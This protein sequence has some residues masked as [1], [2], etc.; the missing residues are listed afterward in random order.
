[1]FDTDYTST[2]Y[3]FVCDPDEC[4]TL[5]EL[6]TSNR[7]GFPS[8]SIHNTCPCGRQM[9]LV[10]STIE[11]NPTVE[12]KEMETTTEYN[13]NLL[14]AYKSIN[15]GEVTYPLI[16]VVDLE[17]KLDSLTR[18]EKQLD[19]SN[20]QLREIISNMT[21]EGWYNPNTEASEILEE[22]ARILDVTPTKTIEFRGT[23]SFE[24][25]VDIPLNEAEDF[26]LHYHLQDNLTLDTYHG[27]TVIDTYEVD[28]VNE[29]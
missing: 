21:E 4:D 27:D 17:Y 26:D 2:K 9:S 3:T 19:I 29:C 13:P 22:L 5:V 6:T 8:G 25:S 1:M 11:E 15:N 23:I 14:V 16:K 18:L 7:F 10:S 20:S 12:R 28:N 24:G